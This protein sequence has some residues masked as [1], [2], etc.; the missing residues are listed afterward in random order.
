MRTLDSNQI[1]ESLKNSK[2]IFGIVK[3]DLDKYL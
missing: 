2:S 1:T 3:D